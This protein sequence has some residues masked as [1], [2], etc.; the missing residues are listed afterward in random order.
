MW[1]PSSTHC[2]LP[3]PQLTKGPSRN[4]EILEKQWI[5]TRTCEEAWSSLGQCE[6]KR[7]HRREGTNTLSV[8]TLAAFTLQPPLPQTGFCSEKVRCV[9]GGKSSSK[10]WGFYKSP[11][12]TKR[13]KFIVGCEM[14]INFLC[15]S[16]EVGTLLCTA[17]HL[18]V[19]SAVCFHNVNDN[20]WYKMRYFILL[21]FSSP[22]IA[23]AM[24]EKFWSLAETFQY[25]LIQLLPRGADWQ[26]CL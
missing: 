10:S 21:E 20:D 24:Q 3:S 25:K 8:C 2:L 13:S 1:P 18:I 7:E 9:W 22:C 19:V 23:M 14:G 4:S 26:L 11:T 5:A 15:S 16:G 17:T 6:G 12:I